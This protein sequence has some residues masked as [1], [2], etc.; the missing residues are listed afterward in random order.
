LTLLGSSRGQN[1]LLQNIAK[2]EFLNA[3]VLR[4]EVAY[5]NNQSTA[6]FSKE[7]FGKF[8]IHHPLYRKLF[9]D[10]THHLNLELSGL[11]PQNVYCYCKKCEREQPFEDYRSKYLD[12]SKSEG[13]LK[14]RQGQPMPKLFT[15]VYFIR[16]RCRICKVSELSWWVELGI[17]VQTGDQP[18]YFRKIGQLPPFELPIDKKLAKKL[19]RQ[20]EALFKA[21][22]ICVSQS[23]GI[24][25]C[26]YLRRV[27]E[28]KI[29]VLLRIQLDK[30]KAE[31]ASAQELLTIEEAIRSVAF[32]QKL[33]AVSSFVSDS[34]DVEGHN[35]IYLM[36]SKLSQGIHALDDQQCVEISQAVSSL[37]INLL[38]QLDEQRQT[39]VDA[40][41]ALAKR[42]ISETL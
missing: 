36:Y 31:R 18:Y 27:I 37:L 14:F 23:Y 10:L 24:G 11:L 1:Y 22:Q 13:R 39:Y 8:L 34:V 25:A 32:E 26:I 3:K 7:L 21:A 4:K 9:T 42:R 20:D 28:N 29:D 2:S 33:K 5:M 16:Y 19:G 38:V 41:K 17:S 6:P 15:G 35:P 30:R 40:V 12:G